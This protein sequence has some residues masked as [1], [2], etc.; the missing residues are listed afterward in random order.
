VGSVFSQNFQDFEVIVTDDSENDEVWEALFEWKDDQRLI[1]KRNTQ[2]LGS[3]ENWNAAMKLAR[4]N[5]IKFLHH[6][7]WFAESY[8]LERFVY[9]MEADPNIDLAFCASNGCTENGELISINKPSIDRIEMIRSKPW[10][11]QIQNIVGAPSATIFRKRDGFI[12]DRNLRWVVDIDAYLRILGNSTRFIYIDEQLVCILS[13]GEHQI[14]RHFDRDVESRVNEH[15]YLYAKLTP[16]GILERIYG[17]KFILS[18]MTY[19]SKSQ[20]QGITK[21]RKRRRSSPEEILT[22]GF[23]SFL[24]VFW[25]SN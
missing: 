22:I 2:N 6:D 13:N 14:T 20:L 11:L 15:L 24:R 10:R 8:S 16:K 5:L 19:C 7:D 25:P 21:L 4:S 1:Y 23:V 3:P 18:M 17:F 12:F 9:V